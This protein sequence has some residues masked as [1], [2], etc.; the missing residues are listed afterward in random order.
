[1]ESIMNQ[2]ISTSNLVV[3]NWEMLLP[4][5]WSNTV[6]I[7]QFKI[8]YAV[9][10]IPRTDK[11]CKTYYTCNIIEIWTKREHFTTHGMHLNAK[12]KASAAKLIVIG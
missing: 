3:V 4:K 2:P 8:S 12:G 6:H 5:N 9:N 11:N 7:T 1:M 10:Y